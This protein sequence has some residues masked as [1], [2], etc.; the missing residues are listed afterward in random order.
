MKVSRR[1]A[2]LSFNF[3]L[4]KIM[5]YWQGGAKSPPPPPLHSLLGGC[6]CWL[7]VPARRDQMAEWFSSSTNSWPFL[8]CQQAGQW[9]PDV[10][11][12]YV[13]T[14]STES[15]H[16]AT[17]RCPFLWSHLRL[18]P[19]Q[20]SYFRASQNKHKASKWPFSPDTDSY[21]TFKCSE[22]FKSFYKHRLMQCFWKDEG[23]L[24]LR[25]EL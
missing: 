16:N 6:Y 3:F 18:N 2:D 21:H 14:V 17:A 1:R 15:K 11:A 23:M 22:Y 19:I 8:G 24:S 9:A 4:W 5:Q 20:I 13:G 12:F 25:E 10:P 7:A